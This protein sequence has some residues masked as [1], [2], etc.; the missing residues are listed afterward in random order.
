MKRRHLLLYRA[1]SEERTLEDTMPIR[2][3]HIAT[4]GSSDIPSGNY[5]GLNKR[6]RQVLRWA[7]QASAAL[8]R[9]DTKN[10]TS[11]N[12]HQAF[13][14]LGELCERWDNRVSIKNLLLAKRYLEGQME[15]GLV[16]KIGTMPALVR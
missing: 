12:I 13:R 5:P 11:E 15:F 8:P 4:T 16:L 1:C 9:G 6:R 7:R 2:L 14:E 10:V 3:T